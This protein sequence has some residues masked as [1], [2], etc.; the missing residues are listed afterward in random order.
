MIIYSSIDNFKGY[1]TSFFAF[2]KIPPGENTF[3]FSCHGVE[4]FRWIRTKLI[5]VTGEKML[6]YRDL[7]WKKQWGK[8][9]R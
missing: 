1:V 2:Y 7:T 3:D 6:G 5:K 4:R 9:Q 8:L